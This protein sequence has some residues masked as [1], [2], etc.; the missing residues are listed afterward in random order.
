MLADPE[1]EVIEQFGLRNL[2]LNMRPPGVRGLPIPT[3]LL[4]DAKGEIRWKDQA[5]NYAK[6]SEPDRIRHA[7]RNYLGT[8]A[9]AMKP[10]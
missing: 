4:V 1:L 8:V 10:A 7:L 6:R 3:T 5:E 2:S 9:D